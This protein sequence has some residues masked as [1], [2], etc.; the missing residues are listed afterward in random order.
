MATSLAKLTTSP[1]ELT[2][3]SSPFPSRIELSIRPEYVY[4]PSL[5]KKGIRRLV[6]G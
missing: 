4:R 3:S 6:A 2:C 5:K 1:K